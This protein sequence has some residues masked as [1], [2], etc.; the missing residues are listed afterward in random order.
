MH[1]PSIPKT[2]SRPTWRRTLGAIQGA[3]K[4]P[5][6]IFVGGIHGNEPSGVRAL[7]S[8][9]Q[10]LNEYIP[11]FCGNLIALAGNL[12]ALQENVRYLDVD[13]NRQ[14]TKEI[15]DRLKNKEASLFQEDTEQLDL[16][17]E[18]E[19]ILVSEEGPFYF[20]DLHTTSSETLPFLTVNDSLLNRKF[21]Q[22]YPLPIVLGIEEY[23]EGPLLSYINKLGYVAFG[24]EGGQHESPEAF[25]NHKKFIWQ[26]I[27]LAG[28]LPQDKVS[29]DNYFSESLTHTFYEILY[30][31]FVSNEDA[32]TMM[33]GF[34][35]FQKIKKGQVLA[36]MNKKTLEAPMDGRIFMPLY[37]GKG[38][39]GYFIVRKIPK[40]FLR[41][42]KWLRNVKL[43]HWLVI[44]P[45]I[46]WA[47]PDKTALRVNRKIARFFTKDF[48][49]LL[50]Y[51]SRTVSKKHYLMKNRE[52]A[53]RNEAYRKEPW[54]R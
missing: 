39:D 5:T 1:S 43:D 10:E 28:C 46:Q 36:S 9:L 14:F 6:L 41:L 32:F 23:L 44:L 12:K 20:F 25:K 48:F 27:L 19:T 31:Q 33:P 24:F 38:N 21:T 3:Q 15:I 54:F 40:F 22:Q 7:V 2:K 29:P 51:R 4:G 8:V 18:I 42:S 37:Q 53:S 11:Y 34:Q 47:S 52:A 50:G 45:G 26:S 17:H 13:L 16:L 49:H 30:R 35:N